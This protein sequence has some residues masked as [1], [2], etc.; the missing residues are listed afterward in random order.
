MMTS[1]V[2]PAFNEAT[3]VA[4]VVRAVKNK[5]NQVIVVDDGSSDDTGQQAKR[6][7]AIVLTHFLNRG[8]G[9]AL[10]TGINFAL[11]S[12]ADII[13]TFDADGQLNAEEID[14]VVE[15]LIL[16]GVDIV[17]GSRFLKPNSQIPVAK[18]V[19]LKL[20]VWVTNLYTGL[21]LTDTHNG[22][23]A[24][25]RLAA[26]KIRIRQDG[27]AHASEILEQVKKYR[28][29]FIEVP[30]TMYYTDYSIRKG[31]KLSNAFRIIWALIIDR[32]GR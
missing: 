21:K 20:A 22:F 17:L 11:K 28:L 2:I 14:K 29:K 19:V 4:S 9:A 5:A 3:M 32:V 18:R 25:S 24:M 13:V 8:Q 12:N 27:M 30:I 26:E 31:Q 10:Q 23:R 1:I 15:P 7:G 16:G 6:A